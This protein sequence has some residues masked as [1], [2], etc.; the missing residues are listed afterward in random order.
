[1]PSKRQRSKGKGVPVVLATSKLAPPR[2]DKRSQERSADL[3][4]QKKLQ[5]SKKQKARRATTPESHTE[6]AQQLQAL[7]T[8]NSNKRKLEHNQTISI[9]KRAKNNGKESSLGNVGHQ[10]KAGSNWEALR[11]VLAS[12]A[13]DCQKRLVRK[14]H[15]NLHRKHTADVKQ[16]SNAPPKFLPMPHLKRPSAIG[17]QLGPTQVVAL[18]CEMVGVGPG[19]KTS[20]LARVCVVND[21]GHVL[22]DSFVQ[23]KEKVTDFRTRVSGVRPRDLQSAIP[24][25]AAQLK[26]SSLLRGRTLVGHALHN[27]LKVLSIS[28]PKEQIRDTARYAPL[29]WQPPSGGKPRP[30]ALKV[31]AAE[32]LG[33]NIQTGEHS[34]VDDARA[35]LYLYHKHKKAWDQLLRRMA[36]QSVAQGKKLKQCAL[37]M[38]RAAEALEKNML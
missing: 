2:Q 34:P 37:R 7:N 15:I 11:K 10:H 24:F 3:G 18:D 21:D 33:L 35:A 12:A 36:V 14:K 1:M 22:I 30:K 32:E 38:Q 29:M 19:G 5:K 13:T 8:T 23:P 26:V 20:A 17:S 27:D 6:N 16:N 4:V 9:N 25:V 28:H 31:L